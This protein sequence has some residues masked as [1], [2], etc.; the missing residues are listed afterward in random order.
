MNR[1]F[2]GTRLS[3]Y[4]LWTFGAILVTSIFSLL[5]AGS[6]GAAFTE[7]VHINDRATPVLKVVRFRDDGTSD[8]R[9]GRN[10]LLTIRR[11]TDAIQT[12]GGGLIVGAQA[13][14]FLVDQDFAF[15]RFRKDGSIDRG[16]GNKGT[17]RLDFG[18]DDELRT[19]LVAP[20]GM[21]FAGVT[22][23]T[24]GNGSF[25]QNKIALISPDGRLIRKHSFPRSGFDQVSMAQNG[26]LRAITRGGFVKVGRNLT[27]VTIRTDLDWT[28]PF[29][30]DSDNG[31]YAFAA[32]AD[33]VK[34]K[35][36]GTLD[37]GFGVDGTT[38]CPNGPHSFGVG[39]GRRSIQFDSSGRILA[40]GGTKGCRIMRLDP[41]GAFDLSFN[42]NGAIDAAYL[43]HR[44]DVKPGRAG[45]TI[46]TRFDR[47]RSRIVV[48]RLTEGGQF[49]ETFGRGGETLGPVIGSKYTYNR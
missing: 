15:K 40:Q 46:L 19:F 37:P 18:P 36:D 28:G 9:F 2:E 8:R 21:I 38:K 48:R 10:G 17:L 31:L 49:D 34:V 43:Q 39:L 35:S 22:A 41:K 7:T 23:K 1:Y 13:G 25:V 44:W 20:D 4:A 14:D 12:S 24:E 33:M 30:M 6:A 26:T 5:S 27:P 16:F 3:P 11:G 32:G 42:G 45:R 47:E 29:L